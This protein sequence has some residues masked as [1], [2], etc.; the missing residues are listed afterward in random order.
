M[1]TNK[2]LLVLLLV[3]GF[4]LPMNAQESIHTIVA[5]TPVDGSRISKFAVGDE[6]CFTTNFD[7]EWFQGV[8]HRYIQG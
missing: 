4:S 5:I 6:I 8:A 2:L 7:D 3:L 1:F